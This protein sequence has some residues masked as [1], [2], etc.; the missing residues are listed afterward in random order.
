[1]T[2]RFPVAPRSERTVDGVV[3][4]SKREAKRYAELK[5]LQRAGAISALEVQPSFEV[6]ICGHLF[7]RYTADFGY[8]ENGK[9]VVEDTKS[10]GTRKDAAYRLRKKAAELAH[11]IKITEILA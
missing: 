2:S 11:G 4:D 7:C 6:R 10:T 9:P 5:L 3:F 8:V 1:M